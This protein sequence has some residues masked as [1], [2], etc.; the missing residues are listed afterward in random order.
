MVNVRKGQ[1]FYLVRLLAT[2]VFAASWLEVLGIG[3]NTCAYLVL[4]L[5]IP[6]R[7]RTVLFWD[8]MRGKR[9]LEKGEFQLARQRYAA[10]L[11]RLA[12]WA[13]LGLAYKVVGNPY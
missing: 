10:L 5:F 3:W 8:H 4:V 7:I 12:D 1:L 6:G 11:T 13:W 9:M 2:L